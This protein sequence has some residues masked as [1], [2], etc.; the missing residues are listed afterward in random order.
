M[1]VYCD[2]C[3]AVIDRDE[4]RT[5]VD[6]QDLCLDCAGA[7]FRGPFT[8]AD[9][10]LGEVV[11]DKAGNVYEIMD[12]P[13]NAAALSEVRTASLRVV[14]AGGGFIVKRPIDKILEYAAAIGDENV[15][16]ATANGWRWAK[17]G[18]DWY[19]D[20]VDVLVNGPGNGWDV[21]NG[22]AKPWANAAGLLAIFREQSILG[23]EDASYNRTTY[24]VKDHVH[25]LTSYEEGV[26]EPDAVWIFDEVSLT[27][28]G[29]AG[30]PVEVDGERELIWR[31]PG[32]SCWTWCVE[33]E[34][35]DA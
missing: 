13:E 5:L 30:R 22:W 12:C 16:E 33:D 2:K 31:V 26:A 1:P 18:G 25:V 35:G 9:L 28:N 11:L 32:Y 8:Y 21:W 6:G 4:E 27:L 3:E 10:R 24:E 15:K 19:D 23:D 34:G 14:D 29:E 17:A 20:P 7:W